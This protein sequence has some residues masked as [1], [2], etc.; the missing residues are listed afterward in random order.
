MALSHVSINLI[1]YE[2][3]EI[4][5]V[6]HM[7]SFESND[8]NSIEAQ[9]ISLQIWRT[10]FLVLPIPKKELNANTPVKLD[11]TISNKMLTHFRF[12]RS[13]SLIPQIVGS[14]GQV[15]QMQEPI[16]RRKINKYDDYLVQPGESIFTLLYAKLSWE[17]KK[18]QLQISDLPT[19]T[20]NYWT[21]NNIQLGTYQ[22][23]FI[24]RTN[25]KSAVG[26]ETVR[27]NTQYITLRLIEPVATNNLVEV[28]SIRFETLVRKQ[29]F[30]IPK[31]QP[32]TRTF[33]RF[34]LQV[35]N[36]SSTPYRF[37]FYG[38]KPELQ[39][40]NGQLL[41]LMYNRDALRRIEEV[42]FLLAMPGEDLTYF[43]DGEIYWNRDKLVMRGFDS[44]GG[45][46]FYQNLKPESYRVRFTYQGLSLSRV[47]RLLPGVVIEN[48]WTGT[49]LTPFID[50]SLIQK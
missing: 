37:K 25:I 46:W 6:F 2:N 11:I 39:S 29:V 50:F 26:I 23:R 47:A 24:Y 33:V 44:I 27:L 9:G 19:E 1:A 17:N 41:S 30:T 32:D 16:N 42:H 15:L 28:D 38:L 45:V 13:G 12:N 40:I 3:L 8:S 48:I 7:T 20:G 43:I 35:T 4:E 22:L 5:R 31:K 34:G 14:N 10:E 21:V 18:L 36:L 49:V